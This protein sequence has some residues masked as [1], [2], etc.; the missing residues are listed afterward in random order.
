MCARWTE[1]IDPPICQSPT[2][3]EKQSTVSHEPPETLYVPHATHLDDPDAA[4]GAVQV[5]ILKVHQVV[6][7]HHQGRAPGGGGLWTG[8]HVGL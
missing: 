2:T 6:R 1:W 5:R 3:K 8:S 4:G 7:P